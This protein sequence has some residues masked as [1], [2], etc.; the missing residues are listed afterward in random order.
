MCA[1][2]FNIP[3]NKK[4]IVKNVKIVYIIMLI[5]VIHIFHTK[6]LTMSYFF[7]A[8]QMNV[9]TQNILHGF[10]SLLKMLKLSKKVS[11]VWL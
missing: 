9:N 5:A 3:I 7:F 1:N 2:N 11:C 4:N 6:L 8:N 10:I